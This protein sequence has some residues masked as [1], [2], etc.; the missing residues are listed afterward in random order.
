MQGILI[1]KVRF[2]RGGGSALGGNISEKK[3]VLLDKSP[4]GCYN[5]GDLRNV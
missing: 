3:A 4:S 2:F 5:E 1:G